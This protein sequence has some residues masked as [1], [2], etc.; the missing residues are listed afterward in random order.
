MQFNILV[1]KIISKTLRLSYSIRKSIFLLCCK[2]NCKSKNYIYADIS[3][4]NMEKVLVIAPHADDELIGTHSIINNPEIANHIKILMCSYTG[5]NTSEKNKKKRA[6]E[7]LD[8]CRRSD[9]TGLVVKDDIYID[10]RKV[11]ADYKPTHIMITPIIDPHPEHR[12]VNTI[13]HDVLI[14]LKMRPVIIWYQVSMPLSLHSINYISKMSHKIQNEKWETFESVYV[15]QSQLQTDR[16]KFEEKI[17]GIISGVS[18]TCE[19][20]I[21]LSYDNWSRAIWLF[22]DKMERELDKIKKYNLESAFSFVY[23]KSKK[24]YRQLQLNHP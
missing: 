13:L 18:H 4:L 10:L 8:Y 5:S 22:D 3:T 23:N 21:V 15:S 2:K 17:V 9:V 16:F 14:D 7:F 11:I 20:Y 6:S 12:E 19:S 24:L 1:R